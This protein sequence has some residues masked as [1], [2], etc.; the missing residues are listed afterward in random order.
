MQEAEDRLQALGER[1]RHRREE[2]GLT[3]EQAARAAGL[4]SIHTWLRIENGKPVRSLSYAAAERHVL[5]WQQGSCDRFLTSGEEP[6]PVEPDGTAVSP[7]E[8][9][10]LVIAA[11]QDPDIDWGDDDT[12]EFVRRRALTIL[13]RIRAGD[14]DA[15][16]TG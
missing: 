16:G 9:M 2:L 11:T 7:E 4:G 6:Q 14:S 13:E 5:R 10:L 1:V 3:A 15:R 12:R 8:K